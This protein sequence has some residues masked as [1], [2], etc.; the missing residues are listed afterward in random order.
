MLM[1]I[2]Y[3]LNLYCQGSQNK[4]EFFLLEITKKVILTKETLNAQGLHI[5]AENLGERIHYPYPY[6]FHNP[7]YEISLLIT[8]FK[9]LKN[10]NY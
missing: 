3:N 4:S 9:E 6:W 10:Y 7:T 2:F 8:I 1:I 5:H